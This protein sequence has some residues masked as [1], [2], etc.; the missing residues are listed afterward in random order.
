[1]P[2][3]LDQY[4]PA[5]RPNARSVGPGTV[6]WLKS[7][8]D[9]GALQ[10]SDG[11]EWFNMA[12]DL[13]GYV[14]LTGVETL[15]NKTLTA[16]TL[17][18]PTLNDPTLTNA[19][20]TSP[21][22][23][24]VGSAPAAPGAGLSALYSLSADGRL[25]YRSGVAGA[26]TLLANQSE[27]VTGKATAAGQLF[28]ATAAGAVSAMTIGTAGQILKVNAGATAPEWGDASFTGRVGIPVGT[29]A[30]PGLYFD[31]GLDQAGLNSTDGSNVS[32]TT[33]GAARLTA[34]DGAVTLPV[35]ALVLSS[36][37]LGYVDLP[38]VAAP[39]A[40]AS[41]TRFYTRDAGSKAFL[42]SAAGAE[43]EL[44]DLSTAQ[45]LTN[46][47]LTSPT[48]TG[49]SLTELTLTDL[50][51]KDQL[52][53]SDATATDL[54]NYFVRSAADQVDFYT[55]GVR[56]WRHGTERT[57][58]GSIDYT[59]SSGPTPYGVIEHVYPIDTNNAP[60]WRIP[61]M[62]IE[63]VVDDPSEINFRR[64]GQLTAGGAHVAIGDSTAIGFLMWWGFGTTDYRKMAQIAVKNTQA[65]T[66]TNH[67]AGLSICTVPNGT[68][69][70]PRPGISLGPDRRVLFDDALTSLDNG[71]WNT[72]YLTGIE[73]RFA[74][75]GDND[76]GMTIKNKATVAA[77]N[78]VRMRHQFTTTNDGWAGSNGAF[79]IET[80]VTQAS[81]LKTEVTFS[82]N[83]GGASTTA[84][85]LTDAGKMKANLADIDPPAANELTARSIV[86]AW[87]YFTSS[88]GTHAL[89]GSGYNLSGFTDNGVGLINVQ[90]DRD[91]ADANYAVVGTANDGD[92]FSFG[93]SP[94]VGSVDIRLHTNANSL[95]DSGRWT[96]MACGLQ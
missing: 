74:I 36:A 84:M 64:G 89:S 53:L 72:T 75:R 16:P 48:I 4:W 28:Y 21:K 81:P 61:G 27:T 51:V 86:K 12:V 92:I 11:D 9:A 90:F 58:I 77:G 88:A 5:E 42:R 20:L 1:V 18:S 32:L 35:G 47:T 59:S 22:L 55:G 34:T 26:E 3:P 80:N 8:E 63:E 56:K 45:T 78:K 68:D 60:K 43:R 2:L 57:I 31:I 44:V 94:A 95:T 67:G 62:V 85:T 46:K 96:L 13:S 41:G 25:Y 52:I 38:N 29:G 39:A 71:G 6:I 7:A 93:G 49:L 69:S 87:G 54:D 66:D 76:P 14:T 33:G 15:T 17:N 50:T 73:E 65:T 19:T 79:Q 30:S 82:T 23:A 91:F 40:P 83:T 37:T 70:D 24:Q 10:Y